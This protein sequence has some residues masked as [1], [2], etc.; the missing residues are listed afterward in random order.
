MYANFIINNVVKT[1]IKNKSTPWFKIALWL[2]QN[3]RSIHDMKLFITCIG[4]SI[5][6]WYPADDVRESSSRPSKIVDI[7]FPPP[8]AMSIKIPVTIEH[9]W[10]LSYILLR[11]ILV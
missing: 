4:L 11:G 2:V 10:R 5:I 1:F 3:I 9:S 8:W 6:W 7:I